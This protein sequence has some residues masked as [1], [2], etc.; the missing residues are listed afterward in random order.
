MTTFT[1]TL[2]G[3]VVPFTM[4]FLLILPFAEPTDDNLST[5]MKEFY[6]NLDIGSHPQYP[7]LPLVCYSAIYLYL[8]MFKINFGIHAC[9]FLVDD[10]NAQSSD[11]DLECLNPGWIDS[12]NSFIVG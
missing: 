3:T 7:H 6:W 10:S 11:P 9:T 2:T 12:W 5:S 8:V 1:I 4:L